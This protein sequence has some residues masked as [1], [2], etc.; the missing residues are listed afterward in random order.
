MVE[1][2]EPQAQQASAVGA[3]SRAAAARIVHRVRDRGQSLTRALQDQHDGDSARDPALTQ[4]MSYGVLRMLPRLEALAAR[5]LKHPLKPSDR[6]LECLIL[7]GL[8]QLEAMATPPHAAVSATVGAVRLLGKPGKAGL[9][10]ALLRRFQRERAELLEA[11]LEQPEARWLFPSWLIAR[12]REDWPQDWEQ[13][14]RVSNEHPPM[15]LRVNRTRDDRSSYARLLADAGI[16]AR[17]I[18]GLETGLVL[19]TPRPA[20]TLP[21]FDDGLASI[22]D[23]GAQLA[24]VLLGARTGQR[25]LDACAAPGGKTAAILEQAQNALDLVAVDKDATRLESVRATLGRLG[26]DARILQ[27]DASSPQGAWRDPP[28]DRVLL[29]VPCSATGVIRRHPDIK[30]LRRPDD[31]AALQM[32]QGQMLDAIWT[33]LA[34]GGRLL[35]ATCSLLADENHQQ[36]AAFLSRRADACELPLETDW[37]RPLPH[38]RQLLPVSGGHDGFYYALIEKRA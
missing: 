37:G 25:V 38:G 36:I 12:I 13:V 16:T 20:R 9:V 26:L 33:L 27:D 17:P 15:A 6:D 31:I 28:F 30:W 18:P 22:Q 24:S 3:R 14:L 10:N 5:L 34:P 7:V 1:P 23:S 35:Y 19:D 2:R 11:V 32:T 21:G 8:Y 29:D 4:E